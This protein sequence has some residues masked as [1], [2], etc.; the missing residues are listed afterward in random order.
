M[1]EEIKAS[2]TLKYAILTVFTALAVGLVSY[3]IDFYLKTKP[4]K[5]L[6]VSHD[7]SAN[8]VENKITHPEIES[9]HYFRGD[10]N[11]EIKGLFKEIVTI[12]NSGNEGIEDLSVTV[13]TSSD[14]AVLYKEPIIKTSPSSV[15]EAMQIDR[16]AEL[17][18][19]KKHVWTVSLLNKGESLTFEYMVYS[20]EPM[21]NAEFGVI[22]RKKDWEVVSL[23]KETVSSESNEIE[24][25]YKGIGI[26]L[27]GMLISLFLVNYPRWRNPW[28]QHPEIRTKYK[29]FL[30]Y[31]CWEK[32][33]TRWV[34]KN[35]GESEVAQEPSANKSI[36]PNADASPD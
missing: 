5:V 23:E 9:R 4:V 11:K 18:N 8:L 19:D 26:M 14:G 20:F 31:L 32:V 34:G 35:G 16:Q 17:S 22:P 36:Q 7:L 28:N 12:S 21:I 2:F 24:S 29:S 1:S 13:S 25:V 27:A 33:P 10:E 3:A 30:H 15:K 6:S